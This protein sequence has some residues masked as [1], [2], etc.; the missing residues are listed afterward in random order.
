MI[1]GVLA[2]DHRPYIK[3]IIG[4]KQVVQVLPVL[5]D[6]GFNGELKIPERTVRELG[7]E[8]THITAVLLADETGKEVPA[9]L[10]HISLESTRKMVNVIVAASIPTIG[11]K[12]LN[13][14][15]YKLAVNFVSREVVLDTEINNEDVDDVM[16]DIRKEVKDNLG[17]E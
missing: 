6:T 9:S 3:V 8:I 1:K 10:A 2:K 13:D 7:L 11:T 12:L 16:E 17:D 14:F 4:W 15:G 5:I